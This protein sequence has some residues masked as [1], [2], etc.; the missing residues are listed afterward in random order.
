M[1]VV[2]VPPDKVFGVAGVAVLP[3]WVCGV[4]ALP[5]WACATT[6]TGT[7]TASAVRN[8]PTPSGTRTR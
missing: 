3:D 7:Q 6:A 4:A 2:A 5:D 1:A 8:V